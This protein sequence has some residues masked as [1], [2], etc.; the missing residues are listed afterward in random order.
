MELVMEP[1]MRCGDE[2]AAAVRELQLILQ[3]LGTCQGNMAGR[4]THT[5]CAH[6]D[7][8]HA[9]AHTSHVHTHTHTHYTCTR[10]HY[11]CTHTF[12][13]TYTFA[14]T[15]P[16]R[17][18]TQRHNSSNKCTHTWKMVRALFVREIH[19]NSTQQS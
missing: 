18:T 9:H 7:T 2:A 14:Q 5:P 3:A 1:E 19:A 16:L 8:T 10:T 15:L 17:T 12:T 11:T 13:R 6:T 4:D